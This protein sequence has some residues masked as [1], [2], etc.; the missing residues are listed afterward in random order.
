MIAYYCKVLNF[1][2]QIG[3]AAP[4]FL[5]QFTSVPSPL[6]ALQP[7]A[8]LFSYSYVHS[9]SLKNTPFAACTFVLII[10]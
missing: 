3:K 5:K 9:F 10:K 6:F 4:F 2:I 1:T 7:F 8:Q